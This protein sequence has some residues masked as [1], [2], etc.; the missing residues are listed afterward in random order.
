[1]FDAIDGY[2]R[3]GEIVEL[4]LPPSTVA[5]RLELACTFF[6]RLWRYDQVVFDIS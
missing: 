3:I 1:M 4:A 2:R 5:L 6:E